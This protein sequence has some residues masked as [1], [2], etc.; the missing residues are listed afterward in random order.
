[1]TG[2][3]R[4]V[5]RAVVRR[6]W[7]SLLGLV[8][9]VGVIGTVV[10]ATAAGARRTSSVL[11]RA[12][13]ETAATDLRVQVDAGPAVV[14]DVAA[15]LKASAA[16]TELARHRILPVDAGTEFDLVLHGD[17][18]GLIGT[19]I[20]RPVS[21]VGRL[22]DPGRADE[23]TLNE[24]AADL[25]GVGIGDRFAVHT[26][27]PDDIEP[28]ISG[29][30]FPGFN[31]PDLDL[32]VVGIARTLED[33]Q[34]GETFAGPR[35]LVSPAFFTDHADV[36][37][38]P[39]VFELRLDDPTTGRAQVEAIATDVAG[40]A[41][42]SSADSEEIYGDSVE[43]A[44]GVLTA[45][46]VVFTV[47]AALAGLLVV[48]QAVARQVQA[49]SV[50]E[51][52]LEALGVARRTRMLVVGLPGALAAG[53]GAALA[54]L[55]SVLA[56]PLFPIGLARRAEAD[57]G[58]RVD[59][60]VAVG[61]ALVLTALMGA[62]VLFRAV[63]RPGAGDDRRPRLASVLS[64][65]APGGAVPLIG[66]RLALDPGRGR[67]AVPVRSAILGAAVGV[68]GVAGV[69]VVTASLDALVDEPARWGWTWSS[70]PEMEDA[71]RVR[72]TI[73][74]DERLAAAAFLDQAAVDLGDVEVTGNA[75]E[76]LR[77]ATELTLRRG[78]YPTGAGEVAVGRRTA[79]DLGLSIGDTVEASTPEGGVE[80]TV[81]GEV[82]LPIN[83]NASPGEG[84]LLTPEGL[85]RVRSSDGFETLLLT[86]PEG[87]AGRDL[88][89][90]LEEDYELTFSSYSR[91]SVPGDVSNLDGVRTMTVVLGGFFAVLAVVGLAHL[92]AISSR[93]RR[94][95]FAVLRAL[96]MRRRQ[97]RRSVALQAVVITM[98]GLV[99][100]LPAGLVVGRASWRLMVT[101]V[102]VV[103]DPTQPW[104]LLV[105]VV[106]AVL[107]LSV[108]VAA[109]P[110]WGSGRRRPAAILRAE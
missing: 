35:A 70:T 47:V 91:A 23:V 95:D 37:G 64:A 7:R 3:G 65:Q 89:R 61:G 46:L 109:V 11:D 99:L 76:Q 62:V 31:G 42:V 49:S 43:R 60:S 55:G 58:V 33:L 57:D 26:F 82:V 104:A 2:A 32:E 84:V 100:G 6:A 54:G 40:D 59:P 28:I 25:L 88:E 44:V 107:V 51:R 17:P 96:G 92:L 102:G 41:D 30:R 63:R 71:D 29:E 27:A 87:V 69:A 39:E 18:D 85:D 45:G 79:E 73:A 12:R 103:D 10:L 68:L 1:M 48:G 24:I 75:L 20:D 38:F 4:M 98:V 67:R 90:E 93:R 8:L 86:Y 106:P 36:G 5:V 50:D 15:A 105:L 97:I 108:A 101:D 19:A 66:T 13:V 14:A 34:G 110:A 83:D 52:T 53:V 21:Q 72:D 77:G 22:P 81:V 78:A 94:V 16:V 80:L 9:V 74:D 56:S